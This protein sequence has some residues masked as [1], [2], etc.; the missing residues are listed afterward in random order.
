MAELRWSGEMTPANW[1]GSERFYTDEKD[2][3]GLK[4][5]SF[6]HCGLRWRGI[7]YSDGDRA[8]LAVA[9]LSGLAFQRGTQ[10]SLNKYSGYSRPSVL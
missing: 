10:Q 8:A 5:I 7:G 2:E 6:R 4:K 3:F 9:P 1:I